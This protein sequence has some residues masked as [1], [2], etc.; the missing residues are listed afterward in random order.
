MEIDYSDN[1]L[2]DL[3]YWKQNGTPIIKVRITKLIEAI[4][5]SPFSGIG[6]PELLRHELAGKWSRRINDKNRDI[7]NVINQRIKIYSLRGHYGDK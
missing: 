5:Q 1:A 2:N 6:K 3:A 7:Y 4:G